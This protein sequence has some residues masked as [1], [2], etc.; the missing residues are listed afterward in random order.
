MAC[1]KVEFCLKK[2][3]HPKFSVIFYR[4]SEKQRQCV[5]VRVAQETLTLLMEIK[6]KR[7]RTARIRSKD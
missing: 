6:S 3:N 5:A 1:L 4:K 7:N 2:K